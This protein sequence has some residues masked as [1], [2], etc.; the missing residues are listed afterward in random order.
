VTVKAKLKNDRLII[1][2]KLKTPELSRSGKTL[3]I[4]SS[5][6]VQKCAAQF[7]GK[8]I[9]VNANAFVRSL[10]TQDSKSRSM[11]RKRAT[12]RERHVVRQPKTGEVII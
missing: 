5:H 4:A 2:L 12:T 1:S 10:E 3:V 8:D 7:E 6:G 11:P 9:L